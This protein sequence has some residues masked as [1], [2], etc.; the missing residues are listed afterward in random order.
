MKQQ[1]VKF[2]LIALCAAVALG[3][4]GMARAQSGDAILD[5]LMKKGVINQR[6]A[7]EVRE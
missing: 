5:L 4:A 3:G 1:G 6:E 7:N 2:I